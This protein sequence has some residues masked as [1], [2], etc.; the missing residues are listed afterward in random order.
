MD[1]MTR[2]A[3]IVNRNAANGR[4]GKAWPDVEQAIRRVL[5]NFAVYF[6][7]YTGHATGLVRNALMDGHNRIVSFGGDG[8]HNEVL[9][10]FFSGGAPINPE[11]ALAL[12]PHGTGC[13][14]ARTLGLPRGRDAAAWLASPHTIPCDVGRVSF[15]LPDGSY[16][17][18]YF[19]NV[20]D[21]GAGGEVVRR[22]NQT[23]KF[24]GGFAS[25]LYGC[26]ATLATYRN[27]HV[28]L[29][30]DGV[31]R[32]GR[33]VNVIVANGQYYGGGMHV[34]PEARLDSGEFDVYVI[35]DIRRLEA[36]MNLP[37]LYRGLLLKRID[38]VEYFRARRIAAYSDETVLLNLDGEQPGRLPIRIE[39]IPS[40]IRLV[41]DRPAPPRE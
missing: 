3:I 32:E 26:V 23:T 17:I 34:A 39:I 5:G 35:G 15:T 6:T 27:P 18:R 31:V 11:A 14:L 24:F 2:F 22:V 38:K 7:E 4:A 25:F 9:N 29:E 19:I 41:A 28:L 36:I 10:G 33:L 8:T 20:A 13:D 1:T 12:I 21:F 40:A 30:L 37:K 16:D